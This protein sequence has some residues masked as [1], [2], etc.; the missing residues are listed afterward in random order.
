M[1]KTKIDFNLTD[2][3]IKI[4]EPLFEQVREEIFNNRKKVG[5]IIARLY[6]N[7][8]SQAAYIPYDIACKMG[9]IYD[10]MPER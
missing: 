4:L 2:E 5:I 9:Q 8:P 6:K 7:V 3:Q 10:Q 1:Q